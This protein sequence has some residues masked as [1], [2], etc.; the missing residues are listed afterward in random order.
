MEIFGT[1]M[2]LVVMLGATWFIVWLYILLP[3]EMAQDRNR[4]A[5]VWVL[6]SIFMSPIL[7]IFLLWLMGPVEAADV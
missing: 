2:M 5:L 1:L 4:S 7:S 3:A 6:V